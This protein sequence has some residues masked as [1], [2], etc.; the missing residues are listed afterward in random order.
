[1][2]MMIRLL[3]LLLLLLPVARIELRP[4]KGAQAH[5]DLEAHA[6]Q[7]GVA[8][9]RARPGAPGAAPRCSAL[10][11]RMSRPNFAQLWP[12]APRTRRGPWRRSS[13]DW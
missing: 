2:M 5:G 11:R 10:R 4:V 3:L 8:A 9:R 13:G 7:H 6:P 12:A 1:M